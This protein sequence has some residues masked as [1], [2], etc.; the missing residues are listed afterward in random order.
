MEA[1][2]PERRHTPVAGMAYDTDQMAAEC[3]DHEHVLVAQQVQV[4]NLAWVG[5]EVQVGDGVL[6]F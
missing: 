1:V 2:E 4:R 6:S 3:L 5:D